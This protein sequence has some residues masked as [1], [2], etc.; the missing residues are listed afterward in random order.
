MFKAYVICTTPRSGSTLLCRLLAS[1]GKTGNPD[2]FYH[3]PQFMAEWAAEWGVA[4]EERNSPDSFDRAY[5]AAAIQAGRANTDI[6][7]IRLQ[8]GYLPL[9]SKTLDQIYP[10][11]NTD[12]ERFSQAFGEPLYI[13]LS[14]SDKVAQAVSLVRA[15]QSGLWHRNA[16]GTDYERLGAAQDPS[17]DFNRLHREILN[18]TKE[19][20]GWSA[21]FANQEIKPYCVSYEQLS[22]RPNDT[23]QDICRAVGV[24]LDGISDIKPRL[25]KLSDVINDEWIRRYNSDAS[26]IGYP[27]KI[28]E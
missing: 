21:W 14:R 4:K 1:T 11:C 13:H 15:E 26:H 28:F 12:A 3:K 23:L 8:S 19:D 25:A 10:G 7:G 2:S 16:D 22:E 6:F 18:L 9:L 24:G 5:L 17:Y 27:R 20:L